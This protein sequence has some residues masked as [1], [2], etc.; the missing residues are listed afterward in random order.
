[1]CIKLINIPEN[2]CDKK[3]VDNNLLDVLGKKLQFFVGLLL[4]KLLSWI[5]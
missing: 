5:V 1:M 3:K 4:E 2:I